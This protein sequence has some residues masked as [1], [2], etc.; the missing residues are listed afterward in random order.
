MLSF[1]DHEKRK[2]HT[3]AGT[4]PDCTQVAEL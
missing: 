1:N 3:K 4:R 2:A